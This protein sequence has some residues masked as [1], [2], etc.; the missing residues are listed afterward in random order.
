MRQD[1]NEKLAILKT[2]VNDLLEE[3]KDR[4]PMFYQFRSFS[5]DEISQALIQLCE[6]NFTREKSRMKGN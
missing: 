2:L 1:F 3:Q 6:A 4:R 5:V